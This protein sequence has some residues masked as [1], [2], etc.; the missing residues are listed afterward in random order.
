MTS[1]HIVSLPIGTFCP[2]SKPPIQSILLRAQGVAKHESRLQCPCEIRS[3]AT[4]P[5]SVAGDGS[6][7]EH[8]PHDACPPK[9]ALR[10]GRPFPSSVEGR[11]GE[12]RTRPRDTHLALG[13]VAKCD[14]PISDR[15][16]IPATNHYESMPRRR[17]F[18]GSF[19]ALFW[20]VN[21]IGRPCSGRARCRGP[22][23]TSSRNCRR[24]H[25]RGRRR[26]AGRR[27]PPPSA[28]S[29]E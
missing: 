8:A 13:L 25:I 16:P 29:R 6:I 24:S 26:P 14:S 23:G 10:G 27:R 3:S 4:Q 15:M 18:Q 20:C 22:F 21:S 17:R 9:A 7:R 11:A 19:T 1:I 12:G 5:N 28:E 2:E